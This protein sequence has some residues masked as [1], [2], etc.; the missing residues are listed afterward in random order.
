MIVSW[1]AAYYSKASV[2]MFF[3]TLG[4]YFGLMYRN[5]AGVNLMLKKRNLWI[6]AFLFLIGLGALQFLFVFYREAYDSF[7]LFGRGYRSPAG[8]AVFWIGQEFFTKNAILIFLGII[9]SGYVILQI[10]ERK[11]YNKYDV[12]FIV[13]FFLGT[14][15]F[16]LVSF[17]QLG[18]Y[19]Y[20]TFPLIA[21][22]VRG[23]V[24]FGPMMRS[25]FEGRYRVFKFIVLFLRFI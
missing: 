17:V 3:I 20:V 12:L 19:V 24:S 16:A 25:L 23:I 4:I 15:M 7:G 11:I 8:A 22:A 1:I 6:L 18:Y 9:Y 10:L 21:L 5:G 13:W 14:G 2:Q